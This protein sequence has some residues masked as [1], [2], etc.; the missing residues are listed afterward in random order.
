MEDPWGGKGITWYLGKRRED[1]SS[2]TEFK[3]ER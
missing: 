2:P 1:Q 3:G